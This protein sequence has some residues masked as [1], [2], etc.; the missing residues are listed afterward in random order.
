MPS[1]VV[2]SS[3]QISNRLTIT[4]DDAQIEALK[5]KFEEHKVVAN[6]VEMR[7][8]YLL[9]I[10]SQVEVAMGIIRA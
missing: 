8:N 10:L 5:D 3:S 1:K 2:S 6:F 9:K 7:P 4:A